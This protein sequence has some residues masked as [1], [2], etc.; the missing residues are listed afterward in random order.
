MSLLFFICGTSQD[1]G[2]LP[3]YELRRKS[4][5]GYVGQAVRSATADIEIARKRS[6]KHCEGF[7]SGQECTIL[8]SVFRM[9]G[10]EAF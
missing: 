8:Y 5:R 2:A 9:Y 4:L 6:M 1:S 10:C 3:P 7:D